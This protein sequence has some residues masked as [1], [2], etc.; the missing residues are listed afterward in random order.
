MERFAVLG[1]RVMDANGKFAPPTNVLV[2]D[3]RIAAVGG[4]VPADTLSLDAS[5][6]WLLPGIVDCHVHLGCF[7]ERFDEM[8]SMSITRWTTEALRNARRLLA[9]GI[10]LARDPASCDAGIREGIAEHAVLGPTMRV[11]G[12]A[13]SQT[14]GHTDGY[15]PSLGVEGY[16]EF[17]IPEHP[18][19][20][21]YQADG[22]EG[23]RLAVRQLLRLEVDWIKLCTTGGLLSTGR[24]HP[25]RQEFGREEVAV[26]VEE[27]DRAGIPVCVHAYGGTGLE[28][29]VEAGARSIEHGLHLTEAQAEE[30][31]RRGCWLV[32]TLV[33]VQELLELA[34]AEE[35]PAYAA[36][37]VHEIAGI[38]G[39]QVAIA[40][41]AGVRI[42]MGTDLV[43]Q[44]IN[45]S[46]L[47]LLGE[48]GM[49]VEEV[50]VAAT[51][52]GAELLGEGET[53]G[54]L[55]PGYAFDAIL[56]DEDPTDLGVFRSPDVVSGV[57]QAGRAVRPH[58]RWREAGLPLPEV[59]LA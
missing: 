45:L 44:G 50:L 6:L 34:D 13:L 39:R 29:A 37:K 22:V 58:R 38:S 20:G 4:D 31:A 15:L 19:R 42:A 46:E 57:F 41:E 16:V 54:R 36:D 24:D 5:G 47:H 10:T 49:P 8:A 9:M 23:M 32:P 2:A 43:R 26:A 30:M 14:G 3:G 17:A 7:T 40:R 55:E 33:V 53:R 21:P 52:G 1:A 59:A 25:L 11:S 48:A 51:R 18:N 56:I 12:T 27:A 28:I 35:L